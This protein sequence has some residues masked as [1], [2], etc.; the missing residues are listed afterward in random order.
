MR[1]AE[2]KKIRHAMKNYSQMEGTEEAERWA[3]EAHI[4]QKTEIRNFRSDINQ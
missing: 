3:E 1:E 2:M 4:K